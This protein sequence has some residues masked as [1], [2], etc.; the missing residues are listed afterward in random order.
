M[1]NIVFV[2]G[3]IIGTAG[4]HY[5]TEWVAL[6]PECWEKEAA[7]IID[8]DL[9]LDEKYQIIPYCIYCATGGISA[10]GINTI[11]AAYGPTS[12]IEQ[13]HN[14]IHETKQLI[15]VVVPKPLQSNY[16]K[17]IYIGII[18]CLESFLT[19]LLACL[20]LGNSVFFHSFVNRYN[21]KL[22]LS[23]VEKYSK[24]M[25]FSVF[26]IIYKINAHD[27]KKVK[28]VFTLVFSIDFPSIAELGAMIKT[29]HDLVHRNGYKIENN[30]LVQEDITTSDILSLI[31]ACDIFVNE[32]TIKLIDS[33]KKWESEMLNMAHNEEMDLAHNV[34]DTL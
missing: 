10:L 5:A 2:K 33:I 30:I 29:R 9:V 20:V 14:N 21:Y 18:G 12:I 8:G 32:L 3:N 24:S 17:L 15:P 27:L 1:R 11:S 4:H 13:Y 7:Q 25:L 28:E 23:E 22:S 6:A 31:D 34:S 19:E 16:Y 26:D